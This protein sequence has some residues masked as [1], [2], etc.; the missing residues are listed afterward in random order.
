M[1]LGRDFIEEFNVI[2]DKSGGK[3]N[4]KAAYKILFS[5]NKLNQKSIVIQIVN[6]TK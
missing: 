3:F 5:L 4:K 2:N 6:G 1:V